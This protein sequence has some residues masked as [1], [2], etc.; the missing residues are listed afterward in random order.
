MKSPA[1]AAVLLVAVLTPALAQSAPRVT[2]VWRQSLHKLAAMAWQPRNLAAPVV[3]GNQA[4]F[5]AADGVH[6]LDASSGKARWHHKTSEPVAGQPLLVDGKLYFVTSDGQVDAVDAKTGARVWAKATQLQAV[7]HA[8][9]ATDGERLFVL[10]D[11]AVL[12][13][14][15]RRDGKVL[16]RNSRAVTRDFLVEGH[17]APVVHGGVV[18]AGLANGKMIAL[19]ARDG[20]LVWEVALF[21]RGAGPYVDVDNTPIVGNVAGKDVLFV[22]GHNSG[23]HA[24]S[25]VNGERIWRYVATGLGQPVLSKG[26]LYS[27]EPGGGV[28]VVD[29]ASGKRVMARKL[30]GNPSGQVALAGKWLLVPTSGGLQ[31]VDK[32]TGHTVWHVV[33]EYG[34]GAA[35]SVRKDGVWALANNGTAWRLS[36]K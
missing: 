18:Y 25:T 33:D 23:M 36:L 30:A 12:T 29:A 35:P 3:I 5:A 4:V 8:G 22:T 34:F 19:A 28:H 26:R 9:L 20:G 31:L 16:W 2:P 10:A 24:I 32:G 6:T 21:K 7:V 13:A 1:I 14:V 11:P 15:R 27:V 17:G